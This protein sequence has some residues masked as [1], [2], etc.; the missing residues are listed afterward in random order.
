MLA[1]RLLQLG[2][3][4][5]CTEAAS[6]KGWY[7]EI[8]KH[9]TRLAQNECYYH[10]RHMLDMSKTPKMVVIVHRTPEYRLFNCLSH[11]HTVLAEQT[12]LFRAV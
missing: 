12:M 4:A 6:I 8:F 10:S 7:M 3:A 2:D 9:V 11:A 1:C 5:A